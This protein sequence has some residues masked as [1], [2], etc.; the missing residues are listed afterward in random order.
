MFHQPNLRAYDATHSILGDLI[1]ATTA[2][3]G[4]LVTLPVL[5][6][7]E[8]VIGAKM[9]SRAQYNAAGVTASF[10]PHQRVIITAVQ[11]ATVPVTGLPGATAETYGSET[12]SH[13]DVAAGQTVNLPLP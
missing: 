12:I 1:D 11:A 10:I 2:K 9:A 3:Y 4:S 6:L 13:V 7:T 8:D 5:S